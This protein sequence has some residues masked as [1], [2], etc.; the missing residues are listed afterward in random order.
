MR[1]IAL[2]F[3]GNGA[4]AVY[5]TGAVPAFGAIV[6][7]RWVPAAQD[8][9]PGPSAAVVTVWVQ[10]S[11]EADTGLAQVVYTGSSKVLGNDFVDSLNDTGG[12]YFYAAGDVIKGRVLP[13][14]TGAYSGKLYVYMDEPRF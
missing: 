3:S 2:S 14:D 10:D 13:T 6:Q 12:H 8:T 7:A 5:D 1:K 9:G 11:K 4:A